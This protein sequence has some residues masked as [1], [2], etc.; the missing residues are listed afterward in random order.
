MMKKLFRDTRGAGMVEYILVIGMVALLSIAAF[1]GFQK[2]MRK[3][4]VEQA[5]T[6]G[7]INHG[8]GNLR[9]RCRWLSPGEVARACYT[10]A[11]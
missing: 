6:V 7:Q 10:G 5:K 9:G 8:A 2:S 1:K 3:K 4:V 11:P